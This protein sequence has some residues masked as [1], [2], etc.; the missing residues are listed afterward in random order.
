MFFKVR[1]CILILFQ[2]MSK[3]IWQAIVKQMSL[4]AHRKT[5]IGSCVRKHQILSFFHMASNR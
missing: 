5:A 3:W 4:E 2:Q 1:K